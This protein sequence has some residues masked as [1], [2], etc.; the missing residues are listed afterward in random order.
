[1]YYAYLGA[2]LK[3]SQGE[4]DAARG[5]ARPYQDVAHPEWKA[6][7]KGILSP[8]VLGVESEAGSDKGDASGDALT[9]SLEVKLEGPRV[10]IDT[11]HVSAVEVRLYPINLEV[12]FSNNPTALEGGEVNVSPLVKPSF[13]RSVK[14]EA[15]GSTTFDLPSE[16]SDRALQV[17]VRVGGLSRV[18]SYAPQSF[19]QHVFKQRGLLRVTDTS[20]EARGL[21]GVYLKVYV[22]LKS[23]TVR[24]YKDGYTDHR[25]VFDYVNANPAP[26]LNTI[27]SFMIL[28]LTQSH[29]SATRSV[30]PPA[31]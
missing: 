16:W 29:G 19:K 24:F 9:Q 25:G 4:V 26:A 3:I 12:L 10:M 22:K 11:H 28:T 5:L 8:A 18:L 31:H 20:K 6:R 2:Y 1:M 14:T 7:F 30:E 15:D 23:G 13:E 27:K 17:E 21:S